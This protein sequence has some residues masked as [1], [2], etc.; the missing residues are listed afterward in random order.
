MDDP[1]ALLDSRR[2]HHGSVV[3]I[4]VSPDG[5]RIA[6]VGPFRKMQLWSTTGPPISSSPLGAAASPSDLPVHERVPPALVAF[7]PT[8]D[9]LFTVDNA[10][11]RSVT[12]RAWDP[13]T[14]RL[15]AEMGFDEPITCLMPSGREDVFVGSFRGSIAHVG[16]DGR[17]IMRRFD[18]APGPIRALFFEPH[19]PHQLLVRPLW[20]E[21]L[22][23]DLDSLA[24]RCLDRP[25]TLVAVTRSALATVDVFGDLTLRPLGSIDRV[26]TLSLP[27]ASTCFVLGADDRALIIVDALG[28]C[29]RVSVDDGGIRSRRLWHDRRR[30]VGL[31]PRAGVVI[32]RG[33]GGTEVCSLRDGSV[34]ATYREHLT[35][36]ASSNG[37]LA[38]GWRSGRVDIVCTRKADE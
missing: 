27:V 13:L 20:G 7:S 10:V 21:V 30:V 3:G 34:L 32:A 14:G 31:E 23:V 35:T 19:Y 36:Y 8:G 38:L 4:A 37:T 1:F 28:S 22:R 29:F 33:R 6:S 9:T 12:I 11:P 25:A 15:R 16:V 2:R 18:L 24:A 26:F 17:R 5:R